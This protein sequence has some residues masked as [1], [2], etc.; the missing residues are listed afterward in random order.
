[1]TTPRINLARPAERPVARVLRGAWAESVATVAFPAVEG[2]HLGDADRDEPI[3]DL[4]AVV[5][6]ARAEGL[7][8]G[9]AEG[10]EQGRAEGLA[11]VRHEL[12]GV[13]RALEAQVAQVAEREQQALHELA[14]EATA[15]ALAVV[16]ELLGR[17]LELAQAPGRDALARALR[18]APGS[19]DALAR[20][21]PADLAALVGGEGPEAVADLHPG[22]ALELVADPTLGPGSCVLDVGETRVDARLDAALE[23]L[24]E[25][26]RR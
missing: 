4:A 20:L 12:G 2:R 18:A 25:E 16:E 15:F 7:A 19:G 8:A 1:M 17:E 9:R 14:D 6:E 13:V 24:R 22:R 11:Q 5:A 21:H 3:V 10:R 26:L 23:R